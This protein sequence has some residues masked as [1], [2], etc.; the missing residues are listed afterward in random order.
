[1]NGSPNEKFEG[2]LSIANVMFLEC[3]VATLKASHHHST[4]EVRSF[5]R[6]IIEFRGTYRNH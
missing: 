1:M 5:C 3:V 4:K 6:G 2:L